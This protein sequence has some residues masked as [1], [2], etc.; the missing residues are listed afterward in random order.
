MKITKATP[1]HASDIASINVRSW[2][3]S[4]EGHVPIERFEGLETRSRS[5]PAIGSGSPKSRMSGVYCSWP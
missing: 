5:E 2:M 1:E 3:A 4:V